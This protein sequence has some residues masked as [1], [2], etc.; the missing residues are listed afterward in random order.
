MTVLRHLYKRDHLDM[1]DSNLC[2][3]IRSGD[4]GTLP[5]HVS[6]LKLLTKNNSFS[7]N[8]FCKT[9]VLNI[10]ARKLNEYSTEFLDKLC[11]SAVLAI[12][13]WKYVQGRLGPSS[14]Y[15]RDSCEFIFISWL[16]LW[17]LSF[18]LKRVLVF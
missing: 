10:W 9:L 6:H 17:V 12:F 7:S 11:L 8:N 15:I 18:L 13:K 3:F 4:L 2:Q 1:F 14:K 5:I 16:I